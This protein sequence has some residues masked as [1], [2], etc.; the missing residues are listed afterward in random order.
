MNQ[1]T[2]VLRSIVT[3]KRCPNRREGGVVWT[4][5]TITR[6]RNRQSFAP[7]NTA[8]NP[9]ACLKQLDL[10]I[11]SSSQKSLQS[12]SARFLYLQQQG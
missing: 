10:I 12:S 6:T 3:I 2:R 7:A 4:R 1:R 5:S 11:F 8:T 9:A